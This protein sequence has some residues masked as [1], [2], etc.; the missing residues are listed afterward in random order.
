MENPGYQKYIV[1]FIITVALFAS[2]FYL[3]NYFNSKKI[4]QLK[5]IQDKISI[6]ILSSEAQ[7]ALLAEASCEDI[8]NSSLSHE[9]SDLSERLDYGERT[10]GANNPDIIAL[11]R[12][13]SLLEIKDYLLMKK[14]ID[15]CHIV[16]PHIIY[17]YT[18]QDDCE[19]CGRQWST[20]TAIRNK[21]PEVRVYTF[22]YNLDLSATK[23]LISMYK[24][25]AKFPAMILAGKTYTG[26][27]EF[28]EIEQNIPELAKQVAEEA[29]L[30]K[31][32]EKSGSA[33]PKT[34]DQAPTTP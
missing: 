21:Y 28:E 10:I 25:P 13:Y 26:F 33:K 6:D 18:N 16:V 30:Q 2:G 27:Q 23:T 32:A 8:S 31:E 14:M 5:G 19:D 11:R 17:F 34:V 7:F 29:A 12:Y 1:V 4:N 3:S 9:L 22:D 15:R 24:V 20:I